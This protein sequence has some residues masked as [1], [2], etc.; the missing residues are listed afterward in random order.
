MRC[1]DHL[2]RGL[3]VLSLG[4]CLSACAEDPSEPAVGWRFGEREDPSDPADLG[5]PDDMP[6]MATAHDLGPPDLGPILEPPS[7]RGFRYRR[8]FQD[9]QEAA[10]F[11]EIQV[12]LSGATISR[13][14]FGL[15]TQ[16]ET[17]TP[18][19]LAELAALIDNPEFIEAMRAD[20]WACREPEEM[21]YFVL[22]RA[23]IRE[24][25]KMSTHLQDLSAC[26]ASPGEA[27]EVDKI[28]SLSERLFDRYFRS[29]R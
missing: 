7:V 24:D 21:P 6:D 13:L 16:T 1:F 5:S 23:D 15:L 22:V 9:C 27:Q 3:C 2:I 28:V 14:Q 10:C 19:D 18:E 11:Q 25:G 26:Y 17:L 20:G 12:G 29:R 4:L 8:Q